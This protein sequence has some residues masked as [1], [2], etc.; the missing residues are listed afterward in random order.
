MK[1]LRYTSSDKELWN[2]FIKT[3]KNATFLLQR[4][5]MEYHQDRF[6]DYSLLIFQKDLLLAVLPANISD[7]TVYSHQGLTYGGIILKDDLNFINY[8]KI[9]V[10][11]LQFLY[12]QDIQKLNL[13]LIPEVYN[14]SPNDEIKSMLPFVNAQLT[15]SEISLATNIKSNYAFS[16]LRLRGVKKGI[17]NNLILKETNNLAPFWNQLLIPNLMEKHHTK[18]THS[19]EEITILKEIFPHNIRQFD[20]YYKEQLIAGATIFETQQTAH[21]QYISGKKEFNHLGG[22]DFLF[23]ELICS[24]FKDKKYFNFGTS[25][26]TTANKINEGLFN[27]K[28]GFDALPILHNQYAIETAHYKKLEELFV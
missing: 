28:Q 20:V 19:L 21:S 13:K 6:E 22:L 11:I 3:A 27:W 8:K 7:K 10:A 23:Y 17:K 9:C 2:S 14:L 24:I 1:I 16:K 26:A 4:D 12:E 18:P 15:K 25:T 5:F